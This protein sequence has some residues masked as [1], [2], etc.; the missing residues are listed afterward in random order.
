MLIFINRA[1]EAMNSKTKTGP[2]GLL[3]FTNG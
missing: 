1:N 3:L 2:M